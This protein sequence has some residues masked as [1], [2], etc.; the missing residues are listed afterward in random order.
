MFVCLFVWLLL[1]L[2]PALRQVVIPV[3]NIRVVKKQNMALLVPNALSI[4]TTAGEKVSGEK[5]QLHLDVVV[6]YRGHQSTRLTFF[7]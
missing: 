6:Y 5:P 3:C 1:T 7:F 4:R 2:Y